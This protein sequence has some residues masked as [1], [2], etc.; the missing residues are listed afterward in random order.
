M[1]N[2]KLGTY[3]KSQLTQAHQIDRESLEKKLV[4]VLNNN[5][6]ITD[7]SPEIY[8]NRD[9]GVQASLN[10]RTDKWEIA[11]EAMDKVSQQ[12]T[13]FYEMEKEGMAWDTMTTEQQDAYM[14]KYPQSK[15]AKTLQAAAKLR[16]T[17]NKN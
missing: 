13:A 8:T 11:C 2:K 17:A 9:E 16:G 3:P 10:P 6:P 15:Q 14:T 12:K 7:A 4:R 5:E 1:H